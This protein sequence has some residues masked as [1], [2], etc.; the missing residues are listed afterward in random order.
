M[1]GMAMLLSRSA[2]F[3]YLMRSER[4]DVHKRGWGDCKKGPQLRALW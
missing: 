1:T 4:V 2:G 3:A